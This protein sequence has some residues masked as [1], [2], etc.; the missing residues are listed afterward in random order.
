MDPPAKSAIKKTKSYTTFDSAAVEASRTPPSNL[1]DIGSIDRSDMVLK[2]N[3][4]VGATTSHP[5][6]P[7][8]VR[9]YIY[10]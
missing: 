3:G 8:E 9:I 4:E 5:G 2:R 10:L 1:G 6:E 7:L